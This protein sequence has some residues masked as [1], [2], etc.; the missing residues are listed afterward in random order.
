MGACLSNSTLKI[1]VYTIC[2][3]EGKFVD[4]WANSNTEADYRLVCDTGSTDDTKEKLIAAG[5]TVIP[6]TVSPWRFDVA[7]NTALNLLPSDIDVC[8]W[9]DLDEALLPGWRQQLEEK[10]EKDAT[11]VNH[12]Y[13]NN[14]NAW[15]WHS[16]IH[17]RHHCRWVGAVHETLS[18]SIPEKQIWIPELYLDEK[19]DITKDRKS[20]LNLLLKKIQE[21]DK[22]WRTYYFLA[23][24]YQT[25]NMM[26][27][28]IAARID[29]YNACNDGAV[30]K[31]YIAKNI[32]RNYAEIKD[33]ASADKWFRIA[34]DESNE[35][36]SWFSYAEFC[37][38]N[39]DWIRCYLFA[40]KCMEVSVRRDGFTQD[41]RAWS[42]WCHDYA[43]LSAYN[44]GLHQEAIK[45]GQLALELCPNDARLKTNLEFYQAKQNEQ[46]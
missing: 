10:W 6:I 1:A 24:D 43:A 20:Y 26:D 3:N 35:R 21:G 39:K 38:Q 13:R 32:A 8:I 44:M 22:N 17:A 19:Q 30:V 14:N 27:L 18:W 28:A 31:S 45:Q 4:K 2:K 40:K 7:R 46:S 34:T 33:T 37:Y 25:A 42:Y 9:Q 36:E 29:S 5:V 41:A 15:Q 23:N 16:K 12:R 11:I